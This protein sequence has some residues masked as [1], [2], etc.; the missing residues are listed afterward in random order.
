MGSRNGCTDTK[1]FTITV[2][3]TPVVTISANPGFLLCEKAASL[4]TFTA[5]SV[6]GGNAPSYVWKMDSTVVGNS[7]D[8][9]IL[10]PDGVRKANISCTIMSPKVCA[11]QATA[12]DEKALRIS[13]CVIPANPHRRG[14]IK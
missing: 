12:T 8:T 14:R 5:H 13:S 4:I 9:Y 2:Y 7:S 1:S 11:S 6:N 10:N 3:P